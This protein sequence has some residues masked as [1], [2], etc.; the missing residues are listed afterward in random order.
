MEDLFGDERLQ[1]FLRNREDIKAWGAIEADV[2]AATR[3]LLAR[4][5]PLIEESLLAMD[6]NV[7]V[8]RNDSG[9]WERVFA[10]HEH[11][12]SS[13]GLAL[14]WQRTVDPLGATRPKLGIFWWAG[15][16]DLIP[17][18]VRFI[19]SVDKLEL[20][21]LGYKIPLEGVWPVGTRL[22]SGPDWW[23]DPEGWIGGIVERHKP[24]WAAAAPLI[25]EMYSA[26]PQVN[27][28]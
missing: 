15:T 10:Q 6:P 14:E 8:G 23:T 13:V 12:P 26:N 7:L 2:M 19:E 16:P 5:L 11:W 25:D 27:R 24:V 9:Q 4:S 28:G 18:R 3:E 20:Q 21:R 17:P 1:F 22:T